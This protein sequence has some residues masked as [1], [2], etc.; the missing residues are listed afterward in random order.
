MGFVEE[1]DL[2]SHAGMTEEERDV[3]WKSVVL[4]FQH[5][6]IITSEEKESAMLDGVE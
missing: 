2:T 5:C 1:T 4:Y 3:S 6:L